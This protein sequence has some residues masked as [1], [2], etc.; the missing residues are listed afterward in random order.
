MEK[1]GKERTGRK[2][3]VRDRESKKRK[4]KSWFVMNAKV[5]VEKDY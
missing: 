4:E 5:K 1:Q 3:I 2:K